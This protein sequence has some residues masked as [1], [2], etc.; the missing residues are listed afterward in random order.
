MAAYIS[1][2]GCVNDMPLW[3]KIICTQSE[4]KVSRLNALRGYPGSA[5]LKRKQTSRVPSFLPGF[6]TALKDETPQETA[7]AWHNLIKANGN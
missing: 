4:S 2:P 6:T 1:C 5:T 3:G 7:A